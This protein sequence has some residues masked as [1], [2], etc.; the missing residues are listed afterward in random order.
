M[1]TSYSSTTKQAIQG[2]SALDKFTTMKREGLDSAEYVIKNSNSEEVLID[3]NGINCKSMN[4]IGSYGNHQCRLTGNGLY[5]TD[6]AWESVRSAIGLMKFNNEWMYGIIADCIIGNFIVG[7]N[8]SVSNK[9]GSVSITGDGINITNGTITWSTD[10]KNGVQS[11]SIQQI[12]G[13]NEYLTQLDGR[14]QNIF[15]NNRPFY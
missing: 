7:K 11:P 2:A 3:N 8:V 1:A 5:L 12:D 6:D 13:L 10:G 9:N 4:D 14:I 15:S